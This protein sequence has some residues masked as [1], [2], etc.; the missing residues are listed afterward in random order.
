MLTTAIVLSFL[1]VLVATDD[2]ARD[3][4]PLPQRHE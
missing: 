4:A 2:L 1:I 3:V